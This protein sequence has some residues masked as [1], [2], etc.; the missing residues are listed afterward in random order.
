MVK[1][2]AEQ[3]LAPIKSGPTKAANK[4]KL[5]VPKL[6]TVEQLTLS[7]L[8]S[9]LRLAPKWLPS[10]ALL[11][12]G[13][14]MSIAGIRGQN[15]KFFPPEIG[16]L[17]P[18]NLSDLNSSQ[19]EKMNQLE[20]EKQSLTIQVKD[21]STKYN[22]ILRSDN[23]PILEE[24]ADQS[25]KIADQILF[26]WNYSQH[27]NAQSY[28]LELRDVVGGTLEPMR[29]NVVPGAG[30]IIGKFL[31]WSDSRLPYSEYIWRVKPGYIINGSEI[32]RGP[33]S[34]YRSFSIYPSVLS[35]VQRT[36]RLVVATHTDTAA[37]FI[38]YNEAGQI[39]G[40][41]MDLINWVGEKL[42]DKISPLNRIK[43]IPYDMPFLEL[44]PKLKNREVDV[45]I[46]T[47]TATKPREKD[48]GVKF[49]RAYYRPEQLLIA[50]AQRNLSFGDIRGKVVGVE[51][52]TTNEDAA[53]YLKEQF[54][55]K[56]NNQYR[57]YDEVYEAVVRENIDFG[58]VDNVPYR[59]RLK[60]ESV[61]TVRR[62]DDLLREFYRAHYG[63]DSY[64]YAIAVADDDLLSLINE[65]LISAEGQEKL[66]EL[67]QRWGLTV[68]P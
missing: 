33:A 21:L 19:R 34:D 29:F 37:K 18:P 64:N 65:L 68:N 6:P 11:Y 24:P 42:S 26:T 46:S 35:R 52:G 40:F 47:M 32:I 7:L 67:A 44:L 2:G 55:F 9:F 23:R 60:E 27:T 51:Q 4:A 43:V 36:H 41:D 15:V 57:T 62:L 53:V 56:V 58:L 5:D 25:Y 8:S 3:E 39:S 54:G 31:S 50:K 22:N 30:G 20:Q 14:L 48:F 17:P 13:V 10:V 28:I 63:I 61:N 1:R 16:P 38:F 49:S 45:V 59:D 66:K 12:I